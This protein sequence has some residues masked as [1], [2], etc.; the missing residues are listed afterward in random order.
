M[1]NKGLEV[2]QIKYENKVEVYHI[3]KEKIEFYLVDI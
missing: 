3:H 2:W 1:K